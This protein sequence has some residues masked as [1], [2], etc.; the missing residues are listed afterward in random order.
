MCKLLMRA[1]W[2]SWSLALAVMLSIGSL[3]HTARAGSVNIQPYVNADIQTYTNGVNYPDGGTVL[4]NNGVS[5][6]LAYGPNGSSGTGAIQ[7]V[8]TVS[9]DVSVNIK[10]PGVVYTLINSAFGAFG[11]TVGSVEFKATGGLDYTVDLVEGQDI[12]DHNNGVYNNTIGTGALGYVYIHTFSFS[13]V[14]LDEQE[15]V[16][17]QAFQT[18]TLTDIILNGTGNNPDGE[19]FLA[20]VTVAS[21]PEPSSLVMGILAGIVAAWQWSARRRLSLR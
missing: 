1:D 14:R 21:V 20:A 4:T 13:P 2:R 3:A 7:T 16:L 11:D 6:T 10:D 9:Y 19:P 12:R 17:P 5:F 8:N 15:F 18:A